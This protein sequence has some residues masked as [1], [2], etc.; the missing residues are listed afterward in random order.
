[1]N[2]APIS[3][4]N[5]MIPAQAATQKIAAAG[6]VEVVE[7]VRARVAGG[8]RT[9]PP[10]ASA[11]TPRP[12][13]ERALVG[14]RREVDRRMSAADEHDR[15]DAA[16]V[17]DRVGRLVDV[18][19]DEPERQHQRD[20]RERQRDAGRPS[21]TRSA[22]AGRPRSAA[23]ARRSHRR[24]A[25]H[26]AIDLRPRRARPQR[27]DQRERGRVGH[28]RRRG[29]RAAARRRAPR[30]VG[31]QAASRQAGIDSAMPRMS[32]SLRP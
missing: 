32:I 18:A 24:C 13:D 26:S 19:R 3:E 10:A 14:H 31:A 27:G 30:S 21:P 17:V 9:R 25:D 28:A 5:T 7:R 16:E 8:A 6:D 2:I 22:R 29:R 15:Q 12:S 1:M 4:P 11:M 23:R 20:D